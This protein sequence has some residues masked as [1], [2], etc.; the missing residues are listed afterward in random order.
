MI[1]R[2]YGCLHDDGGTV[3]FVKVPEGE[4]IDDLLEN[5]PAVARFTLD[6]TTMITE[7]VFLK[8]A[9]TF[10]LPAPRKY[11]VSEIPP[12]EVVEVIDG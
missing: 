4:R 2:W 5:Y 7:M 1:L 11:R 6:T 8:N 10:Y 12:E 9:F 3:T